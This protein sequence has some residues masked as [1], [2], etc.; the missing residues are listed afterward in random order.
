MEEVQRSKIDTPEFFGR[1]EAYIKEHLSEPLSAQKICTVFGISQTYL[2]RLFRK[3]S[4]TSFSKRLAVFRVEKAREIME[5]NKDLFIKDVASMVGFA[6][7]FYFS[8]IFRSVTGVSTAEYLK[9]KKTN[10]TEL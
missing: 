7:Q 3:Y 1:I 10:L 8:R 6:D 5:G 4:N 2:S 9:E